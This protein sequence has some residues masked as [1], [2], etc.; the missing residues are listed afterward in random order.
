MVTVLPESRP[1]AKLQ[2]IPTLGLAVGIRSGRPFD[3]AFSVVQSVETARSTS[4]AVPP[5]T[6]ARPL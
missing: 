4:V 2:A 3:A 1:G 5:M 6:L